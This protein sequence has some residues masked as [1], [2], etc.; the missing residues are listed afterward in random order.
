MPKLTKEI[1]DD[2]TYCQLGLRLGPDSLDVMIYNPM[3]DNSIICESFAIT[4]GNDRLKSL[5]EIVYDNPLLLSEYHKTN[6]VVETPTFCV[7]PSEVG[8]ND[9]AAELLYAAHPD[10]KDSTDLIRNH[11]ASLGVDFL[12]AL[13]NKECNF[14][15]RTFDNAPIRLNLALLAYYYSAQLP[16]GNTAKIFVNLREHSA[17]VLALSCDRLLLANRFE[18]REIADIAYYIIAA[19]ERVKSLSDDPQAAAPEILVRGQR[20]ERD[21]L[22][23]ALRTFCPIVMPM[24]FPSAMYR[25]GRDALN[26]PFDL[27]I[28]P[29]C[30]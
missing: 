7:V 23:S 4:S 9:I 28:L 2:T 5:E 14:L 6:I 10:C 21:E 22:L 25:A 3:Q 11:V 20:G 24:I 13:S 16:K 29:L 27:I 8:D 26:A 12:T 19:S 17:D 15:R 18:F 1:L 30:E